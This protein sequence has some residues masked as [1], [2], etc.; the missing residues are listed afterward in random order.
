MRVIDRLTELVE[1]SES[2]RRIMADGVVED[3]EVEEQAQRVEELLEKTEKKLSAEDFALVTE[4]M[5]ELSVLQ[6][7][8][9]YNRRV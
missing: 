8:A 9:N 6:V 5:A 3:R 1:R 4:L 2:F 7:V